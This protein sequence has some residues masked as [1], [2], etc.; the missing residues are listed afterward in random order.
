MT[1]DASPPADDAPEAAK[2]AMNRADLLASLAF[3]VLGAFVFYGS[4]TMP[5]L[6]ARRI[7]PLTA[8]GLVPGLLSAALIVCGLV[9][10][11]R[12]LRAATPGGWA[13]LRTMV[14]SPMSGRALAVVAL[15][16]V[17]TLG[18]IGLMPFW[19]ATAIFV[20]CFIL[21]FEVWLAAPRRPLI[22]SLPWA[23]GLAVVTAAA[24]T[25]AF[26]RAFLVRLP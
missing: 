21:V 4:W 5:R 25:L 26:E 14:I 7:N 12:S 18:L 11:L 3:L 1:D 24:V 19:A 22:Q 13:A 16:L 17:Y 8:P 20:F 9:L 2:A 10:C 23:A 6:E 15:A